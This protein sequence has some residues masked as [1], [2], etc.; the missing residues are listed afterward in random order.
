MEAGPAAS[1]ST[2]SVEPPP[3]STTSTGAA[4][5]RPIVAPRKTSRA[6]SSPESSR[7]RKPKR[8]S[9]SA[10][11]LDRPFEASRTALV[12]IASAGAWR[13]A[14]R[15]S[16]GSRRASPRRARCP[17]R[18]DCRFLSTPSPRRVIS[19]RRS[20]SSSRRARRPRQRSAG[21]CWCR[22][23]SPRRLALLGAYSNR[24]ACPTQTIRGASARRAAHRT[25]SAPSRPFGHCHPRLD[26][27]GHTSYRNNPCSGRGLGRAPGQPRP[28]PSLSKRTRRRAES[29]TRLACR[30]SNA[31]VAVSSSLEV[32]SPAREIR[33]SS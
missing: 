25:T 33:F 18:R 21:S 1:P 12:A 9:T 26:R 7:T 3:M 11:E 23:R 17:R 20:S 5:E 4:S 28:R 14:R 13:R 29:R 27:L 22:C 19:V 2:S 10:Q 32:R 6:S 24:P 31:F 15:R 16:R 8:R 30:R